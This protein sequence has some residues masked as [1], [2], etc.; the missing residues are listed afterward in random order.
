MMNG[1]NKIQYLTMYGKYVSS[2]YKDEEPQLHRFLIKKKGLK[3]ITGEDI[4]EHLH[5]SDNEQLYQIW[6][7]IHQ[8]ETISKA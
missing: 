6:L 8:H 1:Y 3:I 2:L 7:G 5:I 4:D